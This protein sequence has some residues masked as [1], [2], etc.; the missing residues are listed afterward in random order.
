MATVHFPIAADGKFHLTSS[1]CPCILRYRGSQPG[2]CKRNSPAIA[3]ASESLPNDSHPEPLRLRQLP[4]GP[5]RSGSSQTSPSRPRFDLTTTSSGADPVR[6][7]FRLVLIVLKSLAAV[8]RMPRRISTPPMWS[9]YL[10]SSELV[11]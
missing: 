4:C 2:C 7:P 3:R 11:A 10:R 9:L 8:R 6:A 1:D 5:K